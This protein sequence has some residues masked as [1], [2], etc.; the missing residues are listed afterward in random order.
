VSAPKLYRVEC[1]KGEDAEGR[2]EWVVAARRNP[3]GG[4]R[5]MDNGAADAI[6]ADEAIALLN[7]LERTGGPARIVEVE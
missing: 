3:P 7:A 2:Q 1:L 5:R 6:G 4:P